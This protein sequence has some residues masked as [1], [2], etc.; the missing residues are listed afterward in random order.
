M[1]FF[2]IFR[3][4][5]AM[6][7]RICLFLFACLFFISHLSAQMRWNSVYQEYIDQ[8]KDLAIEEMLRYNI[9]ASIT[10][11][12][13]IFESGAGRSE[14]SVKG[15]NH[16]GIK[17]HGWTGRSVYHDDDARNECFR[18]Y[19]NVLQSYEDHSKFLRYN[20]RYNSLFTLQRTDYRGWA[21]GLK[22]CGYAT[23]PRYA[24]K[25]IELIELYKLYELDKAT[26]YDKFMAKRGGYDK[27]VSQDM[28]LHPIKIYNKNYY[29]IAR[30]GDTF[31][32]I[33]EEIDISYRKIAKYNE[34]DKNDVLHAG[35]IIYLKKKQKKADKAYKNRPHI[36]KAGESMYSIAQRY[37]IRLK[38]L[39]KKNHLSPDYQARV[40]DTLRVY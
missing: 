19:D 17:C 21:Q 5:A 13:G 32:G 29:I 14:L 30:A 18:A 7:K 16:F 27:P 24:D 1:C 3:N 4:F 38:S 36:V 39:Y 40:G 28:S 10:L 12:Q 11:A 35:E 22:A 15:N 2:L 9:P 8:Y 37:G 20:V 6:T 31:K 23:N 25:L 33:G 34:R 26:S